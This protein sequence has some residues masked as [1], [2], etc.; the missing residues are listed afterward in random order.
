MLYKKNNT[1][2][3]N[4]ELFKNPTSEY[5]GTPF[6][7]WNC[8]LKKEELTE[9]IE[10]L[11][12]MG[13]GGVHI[14]SRSGMATEY[15]SEEF[16]D[17][18]KACL[19]KAKAEGMLTWL[20]DEDRWPSGA[21]G[22]LVTKNKRHRQKF[23]YF[24]CERDQNIV[25]P[26]RAV[27]EGLTY[28]LACYDIELD[29]DGALGSYARIDEDGAAKGEKWYAY[30]KTA[31]EMGWFNNQTY[32]D[33]LSEEAVNSFIKT[34]HEAYKKEVGEEF[35]KSIPAIFTDEPNF[36]V[37]RFMSYAKGKESCTIPWT[38]GL[39]ETYYEKYGI[40]LIK[41][42]PE[43]FWQ[44][45]NDRP[46]K[47]RLYFHDHTAELFSRSFMDNIGKWC[48]ENGLCL[49]GHVLSEEALIPQSRCVG[50]AMRTYRSM[51]IP[52]IDMLC[53]NTEF[54]TAKQ[55][56]SAVH[57]FGREAMLSELYGVTN[58]DFDFRGHK[59]QGDW[60]AALGVTV[61]VPHLSWVSMKGSAKRD[62]PASIHYQSPW[63]R[64]YPYIE[65]HFARL[66][67]VLTRGKPVVSVGVIHPIESCWL[68]SGPADAT[69]DYIKEL[70]KNFSQI[71]EWLLFG[72]IDFDFI[73]EALLPT[74]C[75][76]I[77]DRL[78]VGEMNY[79]TIIVSNCDTLRHT[80]FEALKKFKENGG[81]LIFCGACPRYIDA[82]ES[83][84]IRAL[85]EISTKTQMNQNS[86]LSALTAERRIEIKDE[87]GQNSDDL[88]YA[89]REDHEDLWLFITHGKKS[90]GYDVVS[91]EKRIIKIRGEFTPTLYDTLKGTTE[92]IN[93]NYEN[94]NTVL[95]TQLFCFDSLLIRLS[96]GKKSEALTEKTE[97]QPVKV[98]DFK[99]P[100]D[101]VLEEPN[102]YLLDMA[103]YKLDDSAFCP[104]E[105]ILRIDLRCREI[106]KYPLANG[107][108][109]QPWVLKGQEESISHTVMLKFTIESEIEVDDA[110]FAAEEA[111]YIG[112][113]GVC[114]EVRPEGYYCDHAIKKFP[115]PKLVKGKNI[116]V[117]KVPIGKRMSVEP[118]YLLGSFGV[119]VSGAEKKI[120][121]LPQK[122]GFGSITTQGLP[123]YGGNIIYQTEIDLQEDA[124]LQIYAGRY[125]G[126]LIKVHIDGEETGRI[127]F[128][129]YTLFEPVKKGKH[130]IEFIV[131]GNRMNT[132][133]SLHN[134]SNDRWYGPDHWYAA[135]GRGWCYE[136]CLKETGLLSS[137]VIS[138]CEKE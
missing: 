113:N 98:I 33:V 118:C 95:H 27:E 99:K 26:K 30:L 107:R 105:E 115:L 85:F 10:L 35:G 47:A 94:G 104:V 20:Y 62:Y 127:V 102:V 4:M 137:P 50:E 129:P 42:L 122:I 68:H 54:A 8:E 65:D 40:D 60:Q 92:A 100:V 16:M 56:Q 91:Q 123:F 63:F 111:T 93:C 88:I 86:L 70:E 128:P 53:D 57:Q 28:L 11:K 38:V 90:T 117:V 80:T 15:L 55:T 17:L 59:F 49:T 18:V 71:I 34:T 69:S 77:S 61:R 32:I 64:E 13:F 84:E 112:L 52:G 134:Y 78:N 7:A 3:L 119:F 110:V 23:L 44:L 36:Y 125:R 19:Q 89:L 12:E 135:D 24:T 103:E 25:E 74:Q 29:E 31:E 41:H 51:G 130:I 48:E 97:P 108:D 133:G 120:I 106:L 136:Y 2:T 66:N 6:W 67:T 45:P 75:G 14:H 87:Q 109:T 82:E 46:S 126:A 101:Y 132:F 21:A 83:E 43:I 1:D 76:G 138:V 5:R 73:S 121:A 9:Q 58:W 37:K 39:E 124:F 116:L 114:A 72:L 81:K 22:G 79:S 131:Y 96:K